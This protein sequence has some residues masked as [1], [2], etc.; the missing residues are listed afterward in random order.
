MS[1]ERLRVG[2]ASIFWDLSAL[3][4]RDQNPIAPASPGFLLFPREFHLIALLERCPDE[5][6]NGGLDGAWDRRCSMAHRANG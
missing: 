6:L 1:G 5:L 4:S 2:I 3:V